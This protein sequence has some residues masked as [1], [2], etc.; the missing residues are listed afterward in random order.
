MSLNE[1]LR[2]FQAVF[3]T[4]NGGFPKNSRVPAWPSNKTVQLSKS[5]KT[6]NHFVFGNKPC[7]LSINKQRAPTVATAGALFVVSFD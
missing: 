4:G 1:K 2:V 3:G 5:A 6:F 7:T